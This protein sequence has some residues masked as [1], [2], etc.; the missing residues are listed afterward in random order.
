LLYLG[1]RKEK[2]QDGV[3]KVTFLSNGENFKR[4]RL[5]L[6]RKERNEIH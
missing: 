1:R 2:V 3:T 4:L 6:R 5:P